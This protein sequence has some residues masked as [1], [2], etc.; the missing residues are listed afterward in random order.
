M[1][2]R[3]PLLPRLAGIVL[4]VTLAATAAAGS[5]RHNVVLFVPDGLRSELVTAQSAPNLARLASSGVRFANSHA[6]FPTLTMVNAAAFAT[7]H[8]PGDHGVYGDSVYAGLPAGEG[9]EAST[10]P[11]LED[12]PTLAA[13]D[14]RFGGLLGEQTLFQAALQAGYSTAAVGKYGPVAL[15]LPATLRARTIL[16]DDRTGHTGGI[17]VPQA[18]RERMTKSGLAQVAPG[19]GANGEAG[20]QRERGTRVAN[21]G[22]QTWF[23]AVTTRA[24]LPEL[25]SRKRPF[26]LVY[27][28]RDPDGTQHNQGD[29]QHVLE[30]GISG[31]TAL[32]AVRDADRA[33]GDLL[34]SIDSLGLSATTD[35]IV[36]SDHGFSTVSHASATSASARHRYKGVPAGELPPGFLALDLAAGLGL[37]AFEPDG[38]HAPIDAAAGRHPADGD[39]LVGATADAPQVVVAANGGADLIYL[40][41]PV[42]GELAPR[43]VTLL[44]VQDY[45]SGVFVDERYGALP[46]TLP[47]AAV[48]RAGSARTPRPASVVSCRSSGAGCQ[49]VLLCTAVVA[50]TTLQLGQGTHGSL[51]RADTANFAAAIGPDFKSGY[52]DLAP[53]STADLGRTLAALLAL[54]LPER[55]TGSGRVLTESF[56][57][58]AE[59]VWSRQS[60]RGPP[61]DNG[62]ATEIVEQRVGNTRYVTAG[63]FRGRTVGLPEP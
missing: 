7:G 58:G 23:S 53:T 48:G 35:V 44:L 37:R 63:G 38:A 49:T 31:P 10:V 43:I 15:Q 40:A 21:Q 25:K 46:G 27:W 9:E 42:A 55:G 52:V 11:G 47:L 16:V 57:G 32:A 59:V 30:P 34:E 45:V 12:D 29:S 50:D 41:D 26:L 36:A 51:S 54:K 62:L 14:A 33:L 28:S 19:R 8:L 13:L 3:T 39:A 22:Q 24:V 60:V 20:D 17:E 6:L 5:A 1:A 56:V 4:G 18:V 2:D 61:A